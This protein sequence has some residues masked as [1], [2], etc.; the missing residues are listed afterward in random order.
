MQFNTYI[1]ILVF[2]PVLVTGYFLFNKINP[3]VGKIFLIAGNVLFYLYGGIG[4]ALILGVS[5]LFNFTVAKILD[6]K[7]KMNKIIFILAISTNI[8]ILFYYKYCNFFI[9][10]V[11]SL[12]KTDFEMKNIILPLGISFF[13]FQQIAYIA[14]VYRNEIDHVCCV[15]YLAYI[16]YFPK[17]VMGPLIEPADFMIR[18]NDKKLKSIHWE[19]IANG[20]KVFSFGLFKK[21]VLADTFSTAVNWGYTNIDL[22]TS[23]DWILIML[24][25]TFQIYFDFSGY[26]DM[27]IGISDMLNIELPINFNS[28]Y[29]ALTI[30]DFWKRWHM[31][32]TGFLT[33]YIYIPL[34]GNRNGRVRTYLNTFI[35]FLASGI[36]HGANWTFILWGALHGLLHIL[37]RIFAKHLQKL[38]EPVRWMGTFLSVNLLWLLFR[39]DSIAQYHVILYNI[40]K[41]QD[42]S[43]SDGLI[44]CFRLPE[45][46][47]INDML[48]LDYVD[49]RV[50][51]MWM[52]IF[53]FAA[54][55][56]CLVPE[57]NYKNKRKNS[58]FYMFLA[59]LA[60][61]WGFICL[62]SESIFIYSNF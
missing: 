13:T 30:R 38:I 47:F 42:T 56:L 24:F 51:G 25:Y 29:K 10:N 60:F 44:D 36:W 54:L 59:S 53:M 50:R 20:I 18:L 7:V 26:T 57:N 16:T 22:A 8:G 37:D 49:L 17:L 23:M 11:N 28:P 52:L 35:V 34:G 9:E 45:T 40:L 19:N 3:R 33:K 6:R 39:S 15:D 62:S 14:S 4:T 2:L 21:M 46:N 12:L 5:I 43:I 31:T 55:G 32:L 1:F 27:A 48:H 58:F 41:F 61:V